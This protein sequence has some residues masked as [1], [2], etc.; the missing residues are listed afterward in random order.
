MKP[1]RLKLT[2]H[3]IVGYGMY[4]SLNVYRN[5]LASVEEIS[6]FHSADYTEFLSRVTPTNAA[7]Y[8]EQ[9]AAFQVESFTDCP[10]FEGVWGYCQMLAGGS[11]DGA[12]R[13]NAGD[14]D[15]AINWSGGMHHAKKTEASGFCFVNDIV[16]A[17]LELLKHHQRVLY[18]DID[19]H[20]GDGVEEAFYTTDRVMTCS[21]HKYGNFFPGTGD[22]GEVGHGPGKGYSVNFPLLEGIT[23]EAYHGVYKPVIAQIMQSF[24]PEAVVMCC[25]ADS[26]AGDRLGCFNLTLGG[27]AECIKYV[28]SFG[29]PTLVLG[30]GG[31]T[32]RNVARCWAH[33]TGVLLGVTMQ[34]A[35]PKTEYH[36][37]FRP[38]YNLRLGTLED[39][40]NANT[41]AYLQAHMASIME[42]LRGLPAAPSVQFQHVPP[43]LTAGAGS[44][45][46]S[47]AAT[48]SGE[49]TD[50]DVRDVVGAADAVQHAGELYDGPGDVDHDGDVSLEGPAASV[51]KL[52]DGSAGDAADAAADAVQASLASGGEAGQQ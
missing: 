37:F 29:L 36:E 6:A 18:I 32:P 46:G 45:G 41:P 47:A 17:I 15:V 22:V 52:W 1:V 20:H 40:D 51:V 42:Q 14:A 38:S 48:S 33:E 11:I 2:H 9:C 13:L 25:G 8:A 23:D 16:L 4:K 27:H 5:H 30:G 35:L 43:A 28:Q 12:V 21:F 26:L 50:A 3:L 7:E 49:G 39:L 24:R 10:P 34:D 44:Q 19:I 31:Y